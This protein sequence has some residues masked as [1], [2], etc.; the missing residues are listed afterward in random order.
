MT[1]K[2]DDKVF[3]LVEKV[4]VKWVKRRKY[5]QHKYDFLL[6]LKKWELVAYLVLLP[7][8]VFLALYFHRT[9]LFTIGFLAV[10]LAWFGYMDYK[11]VRQM[12]E[13]YDPLFMAR[14]HPIVYQSMKALADDI[15]ERDKKYRE[16]MLLAN[17][18]MGG[19]NLVFVNYFILP[20][21]LMNI[22]RLYIHAVFDFDEPDEYKEAKKELSEVVKAAWQS[23][24]GALQPQGSRV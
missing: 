4:V 9:S 1:N 10:F 5:K 17:L 8:C 19:L 14:K 18:F 7:L 16:W 13:N 22:L 3:A 12:K 23:L 21:I 2:L 6:M 24:V 11:M 20:L 15:Y